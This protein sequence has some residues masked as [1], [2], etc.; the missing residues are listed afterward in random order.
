MKEVLEVLNPWWF[1]EEDIDLER[2]EKQR[3][4]WIPK[5]INDVSLNPFSLNFVLGPRQVGK[6]TGIKLL[7]KDLIEKGVNVNEIVY[8]NVEL[9]PSVERFQE[10]L[11]LL[12]RRGFKFVFMDE[13]TSL[14]GWWKPLKGLIDAGGFSNSVITVSGSM[15]LK[16]R[17]EVELFPG[18]TGGGRVISVMPL[19]FTEFI[20]ALKIEGRSSELREAFEYYKMFGGFPNSINYREK[21]YGDWIKAFEGDILKIGLSVKTSYQIF[22][23]LL[24]KL[25]SPISYQSIAGDVGVSYKTV[26]EYLEKF[27]DLYVLGLAYWKWNRKVSFRREKKIFFRD[28]SI[29]HTISFWTGEKFLDATLYENIV[30]EHLFRKFNEIYYYRNSFEIDCIAGNLKIEV[31]AGK[32]HRKYPK[33]TIILEEEDIPEFLLNIGV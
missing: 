3:I 16:L 13:V 11:L 6:T 25:P 21:F 28:P 14:E 5:W 22:T 32:P 4:K 23:S 26:A 18:R 33:N 29:L 19:S 7:I 30:Q 20:K 10:V 12:L 1:G 9:I 2:W 31:K 15:S 27:E 8:L 24:S 17:R